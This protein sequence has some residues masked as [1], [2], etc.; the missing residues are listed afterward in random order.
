MI[1]NNITLMLE[2]LLQKAIDIKSENESPEREQ[3]RKKLIASFQTN[4]KQLSSVSSNPQINPLDFMP[5]DEL[6]VDGLT[7]EQKKLLESEE[8][9]KLLSAIFN[10]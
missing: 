4:I 5:K 7:E 10:S 6:K 3:A 8:V 9:Q 2:K 1:L